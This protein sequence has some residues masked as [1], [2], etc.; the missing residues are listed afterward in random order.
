[1][2]F[3]AITDLAN[4]QVHLF[5]LIHICGLIRNY[6]K[7]SRAIAF[8]DA[9]KNTM[10]YSKTQHFH[11]MCSSLTNWRLVNRFSSNQLLMTSLSLLLNCRSWRRLPS[12]SVCPLRAIPCRVRYKIALSCTRRPSLL[13]FWTFASCELNSPAIVG[14][15]PSNPLHFYFS[16]SIG[17]FLC[18]ELF[19]GFSPVFEDVFSESFLSSFSKCYLFMLHCISTIKAI[20]PPV[21]CAYTNPQKLLIPLRLKVP[22]FC[23]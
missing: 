23:G 8:L 6:R 14:L 7:P 13:N 12:D 9:I 1:M 17:N 3:T 5:H 20:H 2:N 21:V 4:W 18:F 22:P 15:P 19:N 11:Y 10:E 16:M